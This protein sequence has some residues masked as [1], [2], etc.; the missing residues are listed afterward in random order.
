[1]PFKKGE[2]RPKN[3]GRRRGTP[4]RHTANVREFLEGAAESIGGM[5]RLTAWIK[6]SPE[7]E[8]IFW[9]SMYMRLLPVQVRDACQDDEPVR[10]ITR[11]EL[12]KK[13]EEHGL[14]PLMYERDVP[15]IDL[16]TEKDTEDGW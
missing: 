9:S 14:P 6:E 10:E 7:N 12:A 15:L 11:E 13:L 4:N 16:V 2:P 5:Q 8:K 3:S 1:M